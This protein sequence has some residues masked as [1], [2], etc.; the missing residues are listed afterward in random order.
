MTA[1][2]HAGHGDLVVTG[3]RGGFVVAVEDLER[4]VQTLARCA[5][6]V[7]GAAF[8]VH[9]LEL[10]SWA[11][12]FSGLDTAIHLSR[13]EWCRVGAV[14]ALRDLAVELDTLVRRTTWVITG[15]RL[16]EQESAALIALARSATVAVTLGAQLAGARVG[17]LVDGSPETVEQVPVAAGSRVVVHDLAS[18]LTS[19]SLISGRPVVR[20]IE[21]AQ[22]DGSGAWIVQIPG[23]Q[24][25]SPRADPR[26]HDLTS[27]V[28]AMS[29]RPSVLAETA[30]AALL[31][32]QVRSGRPDARGEPVMLTGHSL[33]GIVAT[34]IAAD[35][36]LREEVNLTHVVTAGS[37]VGHMPVPPGVQ[38][39]ALE[40]TGDIVPLADLTPNPDLPH[41]TT[42]RRDVPDATMIMPG[43]GPREHSA[44]TY[45]E[46]AR[47]AV[48]A[49]ED[50]GHPSLVDWMAGAS[51][52]LAGGPAGV[53]RP[54][55]GP[56]PQHV[57]DYRVRRRPEGAG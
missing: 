33:G 9:R 51:P 15:Y 44:L 24:Q 30:L 21:V 4:V 39:L 18:V 49:A 40:H 2:R 46:T 20:V 3:G 48:R 25:W 55:D 42:V 13:V 34:A 43:P 8:T 31:D 54:R 45:R 5:E 38:V 23:T 19:Q 29:L 37:P 50:G 56:G 14:T 22:P 11:A 27:D 16:A 28:R 26:V 1:S 10:S 12:W 35:A 41:W 7:S 52:F 53:A 57:R 32:A 47:L 36:R 17:L 6:T